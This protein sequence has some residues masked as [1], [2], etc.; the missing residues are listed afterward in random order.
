MDTGVRKYRAFVEAADLGSIAAAAARMGYSVSSVSRMVADLEAGCGVRLLERGKGGVRTTSDGE[1]LLT[2]ARQVIAACDTF[3]EEADH[4]R[5]IERGTV[6]IGTISSIV[7]HVLPPAMAR[8]RE[9]HPSVD[10]ELLLGDYAEIESWLAEG[11]VDLGTLRL[12]VPKDLASR[13][14]V[15]DQLMGVVPASHS[16]AAAA[17]IP[18]AAFA[19][20]PFLALERGG[21]S[22]IAGLFEKARI[23]IRP[24]FST[25][26]DHAIMAMVE[27]GMG[28]AILPELVTRR[29]AYSVAMVP[30]EV[31]A[32]RDIAIAWRASSAL[33]AAASAFR[34]ACAGSE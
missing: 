23:D 4:I 6:R 26:D 28:L 15:R 12:P 32:D 30:L 17:R 11:R 27:A 8:F 29:T 25:W 7:T 13:T 22:E 9:A 24:A 1:R 34:D 2:R 16:L 3:D 18:L 5:G 20:E 14:L 31:S 21:V 19:D 33:P 10:F